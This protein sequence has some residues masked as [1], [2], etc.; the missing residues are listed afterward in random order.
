MR[1]VDG[2]NYRHWQIMLDHPLPYY[3]M[4][5][6]LLKLSYY[7]SIMLASLT[8]SCSYSLYACAVCAAMSD[9]QCYM[10]YKAN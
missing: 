9:I 5:A 1:K 7:A 3:A 8:M 10:Y 6:L 2:S 4:P